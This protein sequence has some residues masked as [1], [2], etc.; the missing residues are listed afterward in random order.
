MPVGEMRRRNDD[1]EKRVIE[2][3]E[4]VN[5]ECVQECDMLFMPVLSACLQ[6]KGQRGKESKKD[7]VVA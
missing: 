3:R 4:E 2:A 5:A 7:E 6:K 1:R